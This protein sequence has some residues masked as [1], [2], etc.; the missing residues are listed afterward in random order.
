MKS[1]KILTAIVAIGL[2]GLQQAQAQQ[3]QTQELPSAESV[4]KKFV[5]VTGGMEK[6]KAVKNMSASGTVEIPQAGVEGTLNMK[7]VLPNKML[8]NISI[9]GVG[10]VQRGADGT[11]CWENTDM[12]GPRLITGGEADAML[13]E[14]S[15]EL[16]YNPGKFYKSMKVVGVED[17]EGEKC[18]KLVLTKKKDEQQVTSFYSAKSG[19]LVKS[20][21]T[22]ETQMGPMTIESISSDYRKVGGLTSAFKVTQKLPNGMEQVVTMTEV[23]YNTEIADSTFDLPAPIKKLVERKKAQKAGGN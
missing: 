3:A 7:R 13:E 10:E 19:L 11:H 5:E 16:I 12:M 18:Y 17:V 20:I 15:M 8:V 14:S 22:Q 2:L 9:E 4:L 1:L 6:Y 21:Q 23:K